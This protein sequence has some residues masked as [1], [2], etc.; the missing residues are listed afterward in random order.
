[1]E[2]PRGYQT[3]REVPDMN[4]YHLPSYP[5]RATAIHFAIVKPIKDWI[6]PASVVTE[7]DIDAIADEVIGKSEDGYARTVS[8]ERFWESVAKH[9]IGSKKPKI[10]RDKLFEFDGKKEVACLMQWSDDMSS[11]IEIDF[12]GIEP[13]EE[14]DPYY[15]A[16]KR[17]VDR[18]GLELDDVTLYEY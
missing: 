8:V 4:T 3:G 12:E 5:N 9:H 6:I 7:F 2:N 13:G 10:F 14:P 1:M 15:A 16:V 11:F 17:L 18:N